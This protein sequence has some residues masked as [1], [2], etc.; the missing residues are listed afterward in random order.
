MGAHQRALS[1]RVADPTARDAAAA[2]RLGDAITGG[3]AT[4]V[5]SA[6]VTAE[7][8]AVVTT[9]GVS[10]EV[11]GG[12]FY[13]QAALGACLR[14]RATPGSPTGDVGQGGTVFTEAVPCPEGVLPVVE[15]RPV[16]ATTTDLQTLHT[17]VPR[18]AP[19][20]CFSGSGDCVGG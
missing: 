5:V 3:N 16:N 17:S 12:L 8:V 2:E 20:P 19:P 6:T 7:G 14:T 9:V 15:S 10:A 18:P 13:E 11:G 1:E 4:N